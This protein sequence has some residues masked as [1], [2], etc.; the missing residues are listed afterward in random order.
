[1][2]PQ[3]K[4]INP[5]TNNTILN[6]PQRKNTKLKKISVIKNTDTDE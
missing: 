6:G 1:M 4:I 2:R 5:R 3:R